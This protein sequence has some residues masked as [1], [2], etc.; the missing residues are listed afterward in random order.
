MLKRLL[1]WIFREEE[2]KIESNIK[3]YETNRKIH[4]YKKNK[5]RA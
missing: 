2:N 5:R 3:K 1:K 4:N